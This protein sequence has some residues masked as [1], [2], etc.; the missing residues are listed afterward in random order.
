MKTTAIFFASLLAGALI[1]TAAPQTTN[2]T[3]SHTFN[4]G[5]S[6]IFVENGI[7]FCIFPN[8]EFDFYM[9][10]Y[11]YASPSVSTW[12]SFNGGY[13]Y[14]PCLQYDDYGAVIQILH[15]P[16]FYDFYGRV[17]RIGNIDIQYAGR[18]VVQI[19]GLHIFYNPYGAY[20]HCNGY[21]T[22]YATT[23]YHKPF[24]TCFVKPAPQFCMVAYQPYRR[25]YEP[26]RYTYYKPYNNNIRTCYA[27]IGTEYQHKKIHPQKKIYYNDYRVAVR[28]GNLHATQTK[29]SSYSGYEPLKQ[30]PHEKEY[31]RTEK[32]IS[33]PQMQQVR[34][35][36]E[37]QYSSYEQVRNAPIKKA[38]EHKTEQKEYRSQRNEGKNRTSRYNR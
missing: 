3:P 26:V 6:F 16:V 34:H 10:N 27:K 22:T 29:T 1:V 37:R 7:T 18:N 21:V 36:R 20:S 19:G 12:V 28:G 4:N 25:Y 13:N 31:A 8:G 24:Y 30:R 9:E 38:E 2:H 5:N 15:T 17:A 23:Y 32:E 35:S 33:Q 11:P 14:N